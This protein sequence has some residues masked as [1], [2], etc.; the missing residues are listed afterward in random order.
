[1]CGGGCESDP[2]SAPPNTKSNPNKQAPSSGSIYSSSLYTMQKCDMKDKAQLFD[3]L[4]LD[5]FGR[6][7]TSDPRIVLRVSASVSDTSPGGMCMTT[8]QEDD[9]DKMPFV[10]SPCI[11]S[12]SQVIK[13]DD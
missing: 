10:S 4:E 7:W 3:V 6:G 11:C 1:M 8:M 5:G 9:D 2:C 13:R 12:K